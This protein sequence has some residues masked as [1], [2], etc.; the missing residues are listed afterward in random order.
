M[1]KWK[2]F[3]ICFLSFPNISNHSRKS[4]L[5]IMQAQFSTIPTKLT[6]FQLHLNW[7]TSIEIQSWFQKKKTILSSLERNEWKNWKCLFFELKEVSQ[8]AQ[9]KTETDSEDKR[10]NS[11]KV[12]HWHEK[13][14]KLRKY[15]T[16]I[17]YHILARRNDEERRKQGKNIFY[18]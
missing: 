14:R 9:A 8:S 1:D 2:A 4:K 15:S 5:W 17:F 11:S 18:N 16:N 13:K 10:W 7:S 12:L 6:K 3:L